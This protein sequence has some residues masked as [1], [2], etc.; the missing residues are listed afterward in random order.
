MS[1]SR[2]VPASL[3]VAIGFCLSLPVLA[4]SPEAAADQAKTLDHIVV[5]GASIGYKADNA[6]TAT[7]TDTPISEIP[8]AITVVT[9]ERMTDQ[10]A[11]N[12]EDAL[13]YAAGVRSDAYGLD[14]RTDSVLIRGS[15][16]QEYLDGL[17]SS[18]NYYTSTARTDPYMLERIEV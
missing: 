14:S 12:V 5:Q 2:P 11:A 4:E 9:G 6:S 13:N 15:A 8:Q 1:R 10:G 18:F 17:R 7:K 16:P 3:A